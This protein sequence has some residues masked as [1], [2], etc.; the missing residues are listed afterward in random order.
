M[1][2]APVPVSAAGRTYVPSGTRRTSSM[3]I[4]GTLTGRGATRAPFLRQQRVAEAVEPAPR[5]MQGVGDVVLLAAHAD[6]LHQ[7]PGRDV[8]GEAERGDAAQ[9]E[10]L[11]A[12]PQQLG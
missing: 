4:L 7:P 1:R 12:D 11:E 8:V 6:P 10:V 5:A 2:G 9:P 3:R